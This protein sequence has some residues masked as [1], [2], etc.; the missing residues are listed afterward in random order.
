MSSS[1]K[2]SVAAFLFPQGF[3]ELQAGGKGIAVDGGRIIFK[4]AGKDVHIPPHGVN[5][6]RQS[7]DLTVEIAGSSSWE[8][9]DV[10]ISETGKSSLRSREIIMRLRTSSSENHDIRLPDLLLA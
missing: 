1:V 2:S 10:A 7:V 4:I 9:K 8:T 6:F 5:P 3:H